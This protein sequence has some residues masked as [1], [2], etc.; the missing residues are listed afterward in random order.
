MIDLQI[1][2]RINKAPVGRSL[3]LDLDVNLDDPESRICVS[4]LEGETRHLGQAVL[5][6]S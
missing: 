2:P 1:I 6:E 5:V 4:V 3:H